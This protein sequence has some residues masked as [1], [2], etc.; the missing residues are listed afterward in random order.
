MSNLL[1]EILFFVETFLPSI[2]LLLFIFVWRNRIVKRLRNQVAEQYNAVMENFVETLPFLSVMG[3]N[4]VMRHGWLNILGE[5]PRKEITEWCPQCPHA[6]L[7]HRPTVTTLEESEPKPG[8]TIPIRLD[9]VC[10]HNGCRCIRL[11]GRAEFAVHEVVE[12]TP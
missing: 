7:W 1:W 4:P 6:M 12:E 11:A 2:L 8:D 5:P 3:P 10:K 9:M